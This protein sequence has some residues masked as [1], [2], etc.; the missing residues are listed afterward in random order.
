MIRAAVAEPFTWGSA[1]ARERPLHKDD[2][3]DYLRRC[4]K[5]SLRVC[6]CVS[7]ARGCPHFRDSS[8]RGRLEKT[9]GRLCADHAHDTDLGQDL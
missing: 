6:R 2:L 3:E 7:S 9:L 1:A 5:M 4:I 8:C